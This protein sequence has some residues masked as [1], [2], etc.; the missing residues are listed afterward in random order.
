M[1]I[2]EL[3]RRTGVSARS[4]RYYEQH[5]LLTSRRD[6]NGHRRY[7]EDVVHLVVN[8]RRLLSAGLSMADVQQFGSCLASPDL[9]PSPCAAALEVYEQRIRALDDRIG[10]LTQLRGN[11]AAQAEHLRTRLQRQH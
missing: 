4:L 2:G 8:L 10:T 5:G 11:L 7:S 6:R 1:R 9:G 3:A